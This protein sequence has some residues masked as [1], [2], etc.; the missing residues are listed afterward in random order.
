MVRAYVMIK[1]GASEYL[2]W[3]RLLRKGLWRFLDH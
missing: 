1:V 3:R 2:A